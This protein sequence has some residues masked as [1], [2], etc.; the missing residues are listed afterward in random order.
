MMRA[1][2]RRDNY[3]TGA[4]LQESADLL[5][6]Y[7]LTGAREA[8]P[9]PAPPPD[10]DALP[11]SADQRAAVRSRVR[12]QAEALLGAWHAHRPAPLSPESLGA[13]LSVERRA[14]L[15]A[16]RR[17]QFATAQRKAFGFATRVGPSSACLSC[18]RSVSR[19]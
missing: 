17:E 7:L 15:A 2:L 14:E 18:K 11:A 12:T 1:L 3:R 9:H 4:S 13:T 16:E 19:K 5:R 6:L 10:L 8:W